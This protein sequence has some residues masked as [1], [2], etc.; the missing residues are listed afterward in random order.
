MKHASFR[1]YAELNDFL[2]AARRGRAFDHP[3]DGT[4]SVKDAIESLGVPHTEVDLIVADG[5]SVDFGWKLRDGAKVSVYP[6]FEALD[7]G[8]LTR[9]RAAPLREPRFVLDGHLGRLA[10]YLRML[11][12]D[13]R[14]RNDADDEELA[15]CSADEHRILLTRDRGLLK[16]SAVTHG[17][18]VRATDPRR[19]LD[20]IVERMDLHGA[21][22]PFSRCIR[23]NGVL[24]PVVKE[25]IAERLPP[26][27][28]ER[29][30]AFNRCQSCGQLYW[31]GTHHARMERV[32]AELRAQGLPQPGP[33][34]ER[35]LGPGLPAPDSPRE[36]DNLSPMREPTKCIRCGGALDSPLPGEMCPRCREG[37][38]AAG[39]ALASL[40]E[41]AVHEV[42][43][44]PADE[45]ERVSR[46]AGA[47]LAASR[48]VDAGE[49]A[50]LAVEGAERT[51]PPATRRFL[52]ELGRLV[53]S[54][55]ATEREL[56]EKERHS[57]SLLR[58]SKRL[59][60][61]QTYSEVRNAA[62]DEVK[63]V[64]GY[65]SLWVFLLSEDGKSFRALMAGGSITDE[66][67]LE[68]AAATLPIA[69]DPMLEEIAAA[70]DIVVVED[71]RTDP[72]TDKQMVEKLGNRTIVNIPIILF[73]R[74]LGTVGTGTFGVEG[75]RVPTEAEEEFLRALASHVA[76]TLDRLHLL[77]QRQRAEEEFRN[78]NRELERRVAERTAELERANQELESF[79]YS[80]SH[81]LRAPLRHVAGFVGLLHDETAA[82]LSDK[83]RHYL[84]VIANA[85]QK[86]GAMIDDLLSFSRMSRAAT[87]A[88]PVDMGAL[89]SE[90]LEQA[91]E[92]APGRTI[93]MHLGALPPVRG[94]RAMIR[95]LLVNL[96]ANAVKFTA[97]R[98]VAVIEVDCIA[99]GEQN[100]YRVKDNGV[101]FDM[102]SAG[103]LFGVFE[104]L[105]RQ[106]DF[107]GTGIGLAIVKRVAA[108]HGGRVW[109]ESKEGEGASFFFTLPHQ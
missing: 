41:A 51:L 34:R 5:R 91:R 35:P 95:Q 99:E 23:C 56:R 28:R 84:E 50:R 92:M 87:G 79:S 47:E 109:A 11:G 43:A 9:L 73:D 40:I 98:P 33:R 25:E 67:L 60:L 106:E 64:V 3:F 65:P 20:E 49:E 57:Q 105:H 69:G 24:A 75:V 58:L 17:Y 4:P 30:Q 18:W 55:D 36:L 10:R 77:R 107:E 66:S 42:R 52:E 16:R 96:I 72:R 45:V 94:D 89:V 61:A 38:G 29:Q 71:A 78:L 90:V 44:L 93:E 13:T 59:E 80:V 97:P 37:Q 2:P 88:S 82:A 85:A 1:F 14:W 31:A 26:R 68:E 19:Q 76:V 53:A 86:M 12:F 101:G 46:G 81:D 74:H 103:K 21:L 8:P 104:R 7:I 22:A 6:V 108:R 27:V 39:G 62:G 32:I 15:Q 48:I 102:Q 83:G 54:K 100:T 63:A 70:K